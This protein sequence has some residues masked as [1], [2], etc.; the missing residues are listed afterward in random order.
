MKQF[1]KLFFLLYV[2]LWLSC[3]AGK[4]KKE[5]ETEDQTAVRLTTL[6]KYRPVYHFTPQENWIND[7]NGLVQFKGKYHLFYQY[8]PF[9]IQWG[10][11]RWGHATSED[12]IHWEHHPVALF[13][14]QTEMIFSG[15]AVADLEN[16]S[17]FCTGNEGCLVAIYTS[18]FPDEVQYQSLAFSN[19][20]GITWTKFE[21]NPVL[22]IGMK[23][24]RD[25]KVF[26]YD[27]GK[28]WVMVVSVPLEFKVQFYESANLKD[29]ELTGEFGNQGNVSKI[30]ECPDLIRL[31]V[32]NAVEEKW[33]LI[34]SS[35]SRYGDYTG[36]QYFTGNF[37]GEKFIPDERSD[38]P[39]WLDYG[40]DFYAAVT[41]N[42]LPDGI[43]PVLVG[44]INNWRYANS[45]PTDPWRGM[46]SIPRELSLKRQGGKYRLIQKPVVSFYEYM[47]TKEKFEFSDHVIKENDLLLKDLSAGS[48]L[49]RVEFE[50]RDADE[51]GIDVLKDE[52]YKTRIGF[53]V[54]DHSLFVDREKS[55]AVDFHAAFASIETA[56]LSLQDQ[57]LKL[58]IL[59]DQSVVEVFA[60]DGLRVITDQV[61][62][63]SFQE[64]LQLYAIGGSAAVVSLEMYK[65]R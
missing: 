10:H 47:V 31:P 4:D 39:E 37:D 58:D 6:E 44:W 43:N 41:Y 49:L 16:T 5:P 9:G 30:W 29:W 24:F 26:W 59:V 1:S 27:P 40:K 55:G 7:P 11:M 46:M 17:G 50:N 14:E 3:N 36:M 12:L 53:R 52:N 32:E 51:F 20:E 38:E 15:S 33:V 56:P 57:R 61:F 21:G 13:E 45:I 62:P 42:N 63:I 65:L 48:F 2:P 22:D 64:G 23:D 18:H 60:S 8:N 25:P 34:I 19:D 35:G 28:K 54:S